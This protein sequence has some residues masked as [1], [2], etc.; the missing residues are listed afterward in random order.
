MRQMSLH[1]QSFLLHKRDNRVG[2]NGL[3]VVSTFYVTYQEPYRF[4]SVRW[5]HNPDPEKL[6]KGKSYT[7]D[8][9]HDQMKKMYTNLISGDD[10]YTE[11]KPLMSKE[12]IWEE[13]LSCRKRVEDSDKFNPH[14]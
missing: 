4:K 3:L 6:T 8:S 12:E 7:Y 11:I 14:N 5:T 9:G 1:T 2:S 13:I 10:P